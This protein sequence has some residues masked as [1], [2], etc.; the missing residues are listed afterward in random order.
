[1][2]ESN[3]THP[4]LLVRIRNADDDQ[5]WCE[6]VEI[7]SPLIYGFARKRGLQDADAV[8]LTQEVLR[9]VARSIGR[10]EYDRRRGSFRGWLFTIVRNELSDWFSRQRSDV[11]GSGDSSDVRRFEELPAADENDSAFWDQEHQRRL[12][13][14]ASLR[15][16]TEVH[17]S[18]WSAFWETT[19]KGRSGKDVASELG[20]SVAAVYLAKSRV[21]ARLKELVRF[22]V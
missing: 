3:I 10:L 2:T 19:V 21:M 20:L 6:F 16:Q 13:E 7:Y 22:C 8:D 11:V 12:F 17:E 14:W 15:I 5:S 1:M 4:S 18:T 9:I